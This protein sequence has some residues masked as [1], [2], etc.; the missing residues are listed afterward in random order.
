MLSVKKAWR[1]LVLCFWVAGLPN[2]A[3]ASQADGIWLPKGKVAVR[4]SDCGRE[5]C[6]QVVWLNNPTLRTPKM[7]GRRIIWG[8]VQDGPANWNSGQIF[9]PDNGTI[10][11][12]NATMQA[13][14]VIVARVYE[15]LDVFGETKTLTRIEPQSL[16][17]W[18]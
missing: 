15:G 8:L 5:L 10:Y 3:S 14:D 9:D 12:L 4:T 17:G 7:C 13:A 6:G 18:C 2:L 11:N 1:V 16:P